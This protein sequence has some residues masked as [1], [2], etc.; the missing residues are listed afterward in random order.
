MVRMSGGDLLC[1]VELF[2]QYKAHEL[3]GEY[4]G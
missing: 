3:M 1:A 2:G 4:Q